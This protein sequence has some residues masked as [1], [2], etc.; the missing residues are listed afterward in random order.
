MAVPSRPQPRPLDLFSPGTCL[1]SLPPPTAGTT[2]SLPLH[3][4]P[5]PIPCRPHAALTCSSRRFDFRIFGLESLCVGL[6]HFSHLATRRGCRRLEL[7]QL[8]RRWG[9]ASILCGTAWQE[10]SGAQACE[11]G[12]VSAYVVILNALAWLTGSD[13]TST[14]S[15]QLRNAFVCQRVHFSINTNGRVRI[16]HTTP[17]HQ[18]T[19]T[20]AA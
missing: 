10:E 2:C 7:C 18:H 19:S 5:R 13:M 9:L 16:H 4:S 11:A 20:P 3:L 15:T 1:P 17:H 12:C 14:F 8:F 6:L